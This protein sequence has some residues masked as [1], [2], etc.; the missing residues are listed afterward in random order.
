M[1]EVSNKI[2]KIMDNIYNSANPSDATAL[3][4]ELAKKLKEY[5]AESYKKEILLT[6]DNTHTPVHIAKKDF[7]NGMAVFLL[8]KM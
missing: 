1:G 3:E 5:F 2:N 8:K 7:W 6:T 4:E